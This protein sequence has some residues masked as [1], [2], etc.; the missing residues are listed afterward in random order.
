MKKISENNIAHLYREVRTYHNTK[1]AVDANKYTHA[2]LCSPSI[3]QSH[4][5]MRACERVCVCVCIRVFK[6]QTSSFNI[7]FLMILHGFLLL[8]LILVFINNCSMRMKFM[9]VKQII[10]WQAFSVKCFPNFHLIQQSPP[11]YHVS[12]KSSLI[13]MTLNSFHLN[14][15]HVVCNSV[16]FLYAKIIAQKSKWM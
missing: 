10:L 11:P 13:F 6:S 16:T 14:C 12:V 1:H 2:Q 4:F 5:R 9:S 3:Q 15:C 8:N 7:E